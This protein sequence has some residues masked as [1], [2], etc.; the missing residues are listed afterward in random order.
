VANIYDVAQEF[1]RALLRQE[2]DAAVKLVQ[3]YGTAYERLSAQLDKLLKKIEAARAAGETVDQAWLL[4]EQRYFALLNQVLR[5]IGRFADITGSVITDQQRQAVRQ[6]MMDSE[7]LLL[8]AME[9]SPEGI[10]GEFNRLSK[11][12]NENLIG[13]LSDG[14]PLNTLLGRLA[15]EAR[16]IVERGLIKGVIQGRNPRAVAR[17]IRE[18]LNGNLTRALKIARTETIRAYREASHRTYLD[19][20]DV[21]EGWYWLAALN[22]ART[23]RACIAL[24]GTF[25][26]LGE[27]MKSHV[28]CRCTQVP[29]VKGVDLGI[30]KGATWFAKQPASFQREILDKEGEFEAYKSGRLKLEDFVGLRRSARWGDSYQ[31]LSL[32]RALAGEG[33]FPGDPRRPRDLNSLIVPREELG[34]RG[35]PVSRALHIVENEEIT[36]PAKRVI[37]LIDRLHGD[38]ELPE[39]PIKKKP[40]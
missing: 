34:P 4:R 18:G 19:N 16:Q 35:T 23:C 26:E 37:E 5:E 40:R 28:Q 32:Q 6:A 33:L 31:A 9:A 27:R 17:E 10:S 29:G 8:T 22:S 24:H 30:G 12:A 21:L 25:H 15:P 7:R 13:F 14:S 11:S 1:R 36:A 3:A 39:T 20:P 2:R 38:G